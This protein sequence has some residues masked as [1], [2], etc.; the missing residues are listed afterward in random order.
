MDPQRDEPEE[1]ERTASE[2]NRLLLEYLDGL[3]GDPI[4]LLEELCNRSPTQADALRRRIQV[5]DQA[6]LLGVEKAGEPPA[7]PERLGEFRLI[8][9][10]GGGGMG[11]VYLAHQASLDREVALKIVR[12]E[13]LFFEEARERFKREVTTIAKLSHPGIVP[14]YSVGEED[15]LPFFAMERVRGSTLADALA[16]LRSVPPAELEGSHLQ[17]AIAG[18]DA[19]EGEIAALFRGTWTE[20]CLRIARQVAEALQHAHRLGVVHR[21]IK[22][23]NIMVTRGG[24]VMLLDFGLSSQERPDRL[25]RTGSQVGS[26]PYM[27][28]EQLSGGAVPDSRFDIYGLGVTLYELLTLR[29]PY[30]AKTTAQLQQLVVG[31]MPVAIRE[32]NARVSWEAETVCLTAM[33]SDVARR[34]QS[35]EILARDLTNVL[36]HRPILARRAGRV[37][38]ARRWIQRHPARS[39][40]LALGSLLV[41]VGPSL[42]GWQ[43][44]RTSVALGEK[45]TELQAAYAELQDTLAEV[46]RQRELAD[47]NFTLAN[48]AV[49]QMLTRIADETLRD[50]PHVDQVR[51][52]ILEDALRFEEA[53]LARVPNEGTQR[54]SYAMSMF[55]VGEIRGMLGDYRGAIEVLG[56]HRLLL[57]DLWAEAPSA[58]LTF[59][60]ARCLWK[61]AQAY[62]F[63]DRSTE[64]IE[65]AQ[66]GLALLVGS[67]TG[68]T[69][70]GR[71]LLRSRLQIEL[72]EVARRQGRGEEQHDALIDAVESLRALI[73]S[74]DDVEARMRLAQ[75]LHGLGTPALVEEMVQPDVEELSRRQPFL[76]EAV[77]LRRILAE[78]LAGP[79]LERDLADS[80]VSLGNTYLAAR[81]FGL[82]VRCFE[83]ALGLAAQA[84]ADH[85]SVPSLGDGVAVGHLSLAT[86]ASLEERTDVEND[87]LMR[88]LEAFEQLERL[89]PSNLDHVRKRFYANFNLG[90]N[91]MSAD[92]GKFDEGEAHFLRCV[93]LGTRLRERRGLGPLGDSFVLAQAFVGYCQAKQ[94]EHV[95]GLESVTLML[96]MSPNSNQLGV[97]ASV[98]AQCL[99]AAGRDPELS[100]ED[101]GFWEEEYAARA[102]DLLREAIDSSPDGATRREILAQEDLE[103]LRARPAYA[104]LLQELGLGPV[105]EDG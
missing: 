33:E 67:G 80:L 76:L 49:G 74:T 27:P 83:E 50:I 11:V 102:V 92:A 103:P 72:G 69:D 52:K 29:L 34:Y 24:R 57:E 18:P 16:G 39:V 84:W 85:P 12:P 88:A 35:A 101:R 43:Q 2:L 82:A 55:R 61:L 54:F 25:T 87:H 21:D 14:V 70:H 64:A 36:E 44:Y 41:I 95:Q 26:L 90:F 45:Q 81:D 37:L 46:E 4:G 19:D 56:E 1:D 79:A 75:A 60:R 6:G 63:E 89:D 68:D 59:A 98:L 47:S 78:D 99:A 17:R 73:G 65:C 7:M 15:G 77:E 3:E 40:A 13:Q 53:L 42:F 58:D 23:S 100:E 104:Q 10:L 51:R 32:S 20:T 71:L 94:S 9:R 5:L 22:P 38:L 96:E 97:G 62:R 30:E 93:E 91:I 86:V 28:P 48:D 31:G 66:G 8:S 105:V